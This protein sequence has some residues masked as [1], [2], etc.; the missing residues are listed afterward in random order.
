MPETTMPLEDAPEAFDGHL[1]GKIGT[2]VWVRVWVWVCVWRVR[3]RYK[4]NILY[5]Q[6]ILF[7]ETKVA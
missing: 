1:R 4:R 6:C 7:K 5:T 2:W 3:V